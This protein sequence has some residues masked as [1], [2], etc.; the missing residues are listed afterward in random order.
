[1]ALWADQ[2]RGRIRN[3]IADRDAV[4]RHQIYTRL[5]AGLGLRPDEVQGALKRIEREFGVH[6]GLLRATDDILVLFAPVD[7]G[8]NPVKR[9]AFKGIESDISKHLVHELRAR[10]ERFGTW[11]AWRDAEIL[12]VGDWVLAWCGQM[13]DLRAR[14]AWRENAADRAVPERTPTLP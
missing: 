7:P 4:A 13:P 5:W 11:Q 2:W 9:L 10:L 3:R 1:M 8:W 6:P 12:T 14:G